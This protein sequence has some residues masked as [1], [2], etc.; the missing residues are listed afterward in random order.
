MSQFNVPVPHNEP[1]LQY[2]P[3]SPERDKLKAALSNA[4]SITIDIPMYIGGKEV[5]SNQQYPITPPHDHKHVLGNYHSSDASHIKM[6][7]DASLKAKAAWAAMP[8]EQRASIFLKAADL[9]AGP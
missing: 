5:R 4:R 6:A 7:I 3:G 2:A 1:V 8:W 9:L